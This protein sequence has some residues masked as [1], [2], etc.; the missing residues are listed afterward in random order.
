MS[1]TV[2]KGFY[3]AA[4]A[5]KKFS[6]NFFNELKTISNEEEL[7]NFIEKK[8]QPIAKEMGYDF[9]KEELLQY[10]KQMAQKI[11]EQQLEAVS[12][13]VNVKSLALSGIVSL[14]A[15]GAGIIASTSSTSAELNKDIVASSNKAMDTA[16]GQVE[17]EEEKEEE[18]K[19]E[20]EKEEE[21]EEKEEEEEE[22]E[23]E[24]KEEEE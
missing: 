7:K 9:S 1:K 11:T 4:V 3:E 2:I 18:E 20:E 21:E 10:E 5:Q 16:L 12:G 14:M 24:E 8:V 13:G 15:L 6:K 17:E 23:E 22:K 19:E